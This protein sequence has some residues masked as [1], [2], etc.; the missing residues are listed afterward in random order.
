MRLSAEQIHK[1][2]ELHRQKFGEELSYEVA[3]DKA[4]RLVRMLEIILN[5]R[6]KTQS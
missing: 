1:F 3:Y 4:I 6:A 5:R 2:Q